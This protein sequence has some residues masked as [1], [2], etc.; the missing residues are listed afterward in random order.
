MLVVSDWVA[1]NRM[2]ALTLA[3]GTMLGLGALMIILSPV[4]LYF[5]GDLIIYWARRRG[6]REPRQPRLCGAPLD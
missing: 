5:A 4:I 6:L 3:L 1:A 2:L